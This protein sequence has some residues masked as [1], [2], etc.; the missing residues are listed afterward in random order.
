MHTGL[1]V[2]ALGDCGGP[3]GQSVRAGRLHRGEFG[4][5]R[6]EF[7]DRP[8]ERGLDG[9]V[10]VRRVEDAAQERPG[11]AQ[12]P[13]P[14]PDHVGVALLDGRVVVGVGMAPVRHLGDEVEGA[15]PLGVRG[16]RRARDLR[17][18]VDAEPFEIVVRV[19]HVD[20]AVDGRG[21][22]RGV[23]G[24]GLAGRQRHSEGGRYLGQD[25]VQLRGRTVHVVIDAARLAV[26]QGGQKARPGGVQQPHQR[27]GFGQYT[28][29]PRLLVGERE[30]P[31]DLFVAGGPVE[32]APVVALVGRGGEPALVEAGPV[33]VD[34]GHDV[35]GPAEVPAQ[36]RAFAQGPGQVQGG[37][38]ADRLVGVH[39][40]DDDVSAVPV[41]REARGSFAHREAVQG[42]A[43]CGGAD[44]ALGHQVGVSL[45]Q[46]PEGGEE[47]VHGRVG[48]G[49]GDG[50]RVP[51]PVPGGRHGGGGLLGCRGGH[52]GADLRGVGGTGVR[53]PSYAYVHRVPDGQPTTDI[54]LS[55]TSAGP[56]VTPVTL[57]VL[58]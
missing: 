40:A 47:F 36:F 17:C 52:A 39:P 46:L 3:V 27:Q 18:G 41:R 53:V 42:F 44:P 23:G 54:R 20:A 2:E 55:S 1:A 21:V 34:A 13:R 8:Q 33:R 57:G 9:Q 5:R 25:S 32:V 19:L 37:H 49:L 6:Y 28:V 11:L 38:R 22:D 4:Q 48:V 51:Y 26:V 43:E 29:E 12:R 50:R 14:A 24:L 16:A 15:V 31:L 56:T 45:R 58:A 35:P 30:G 10:R 7:A